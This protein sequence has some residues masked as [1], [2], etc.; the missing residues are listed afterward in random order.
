[1]AQCSAIQAAAGVMCCWLVLWLGVTAGFAVVEAAGQQIYRSAALHRTNL[2]ECVADGKSAIRWIR[3]HAAELGVDPHRIVAAGASAG[4]HVAAA[5]GTVS[6]LDEPSENK[7]ASSRLDAMILWY[8]V[9][10]N[11]PCDYGHGRVGERYPEI[12]PLHN[13]SAQ[14]PP[15]LIL[16]GTR[17]RLVPV[18]TAEEFKSRIEKAGGRRDLK[19]FEGAEHSNYEYRKGDSPWRRKCLTLA[20]EFMVCI[21]FLR[22][23]HN[24]LKA[25]RAGG[26]R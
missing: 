26:A 21:D 17:D 23:S 1:M 5:T 10:N 24:P 22:S 4:G 12:S 6:G 13:I 8:P 11:G 20:D 25:Q 16:L 7:A 9:V 18:Q 3:E 19:L 14:C 15:L 2:F